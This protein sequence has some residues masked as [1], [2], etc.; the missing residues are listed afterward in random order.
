M[1]LAQYLLLFDL[2][3]QAA[4]DICILSG[5]LLSLVDANGNWPCKMAGADV[6][7]GLSGISY[8]QHRIT[9]V[10]LYSAALSDRVCARRSV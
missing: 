9:I 4:L 3:L 8:W 5:S 6:N 2:Y 7:Y 1:N 10:C